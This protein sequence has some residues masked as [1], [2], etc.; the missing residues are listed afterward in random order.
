MNEAEQKKKSGHVSADLSFSQVFVG[1][2]LIVG[3]M[4]VLMLQRQI[5][6]KGGHMLITKVSTLQVSFVI[7]TALVER[8]PA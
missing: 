7:Q 6:G 1:F 5:R 2:Q 8:T 4:Q 3:P